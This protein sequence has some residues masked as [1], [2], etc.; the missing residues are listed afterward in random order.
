MGS[1]TSTQPETA[2][3]GNI[4]LTLAHSGDPDDVYMW[5]PLTGV[6]LPDGTRAPG[7][8][9][10]P[11]IDTGRFR[12]RAVPGDISEFN[13][14][15]AGSAPYDIT[16]LSLRAAADVSDRYVL[17]RC[18][19]SF[20]DGYGPKIV[21]RAANPALRSVDELKL[22]T[23]RIAVPGLRT[24]AFLTMGLMLGAEA[25][26]DR[27]RFVELPFDKII[28]AVVE[29]RVDAGLVIHEGQVT[30]ADAGL[31][32]IADVGEWWGR[33]R[34]L[35]LPLG[36]NAMKRDLDVRYGAGT[37][38]EV[39]QLLD[40]SLAYAHEHRNESIDAT[41]PFAILN[42]ASSGT[43]APSREKVIGYV[44]MYVNNYTKDMGEKGRIAVHRL[45]SE[46][47][48]LGLCAGPDGVEVI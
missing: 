17:S 28:P 47:A 21:C 33:A 37:L 46:G 42:A 23:I 12:F 2:S 43:P 13:R 4:E 48:A 44:N 10:L 29:G 40:R 8:A 1:S 14:L 26:R 7:A 9:G 3:G 31:R 27:A 45:L 22:P 41:M 18:G 11:R 19:S 20:G 25:V 34:G 16:A 38:R 5:W 36:M 35:P 6:V 15:A 24:S 39:S 30:F 32:Q